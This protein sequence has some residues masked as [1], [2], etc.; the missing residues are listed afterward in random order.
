MKSLN[1]EISHNE[2][3]QNGRKTAKRKI[4]RYTRNEKES[5]TPREGRWDFKIKYSKIEDGKVI[6]WKCCYLQET[7]ELTFWI[8]SYQPLKMIKKAWAE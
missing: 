2:F 6:N 1:N 7:K 8:K 5:K 3:S 4:F